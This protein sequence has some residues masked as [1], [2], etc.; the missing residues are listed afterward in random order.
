[1]PNILQFWQ[2]RRSG[3][4]DDNE[5]ERHLRPHITPLFR[6]AAYWCGNNDDAEDLL[7]TTLCKLYVA[8][9][10]LENIDQLRPWLIKIMYRQFVDGIRRDSRKPLPF[11][12]TSLMNDEDHKYP[13]IWA[14][15]TEQQPEDIFATDVLIRQLQSALNALPPAW[16][17]MVIMH[18]VE[19]YSMQEISETLD[20]PVGTIKSGLHRARERLRDI[21]TANGTVLASEA[22]STKRF[23]T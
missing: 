17:A 22:C 15:Q 23:E 6:L 3:L 11:S 2:K 14:N 20:I 7:Q 13:N 9:D 5:F 8:R 21:L 10:Q 18:D 1:M 16:R 19:N 12:D 4:S